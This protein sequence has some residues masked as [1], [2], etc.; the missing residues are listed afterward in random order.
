MKK[1]I[2]LVLSA[3]FL[4]AGCSSGENNNV[5]F[6]YCRDTAAYQYFEEDGVIQ[7]ETRDLP[8]H[9]NDL[10]YMIGLYLAGPIKEGLESPFPTSTQILSLHLEEDILSIELSDLTNTLTDSEYTLACACLT[11]TCLN[12]AQ[13]SAVQISSGNRSIRMSNETMILFDSLPQQ[14]TTGG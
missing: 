5:P 13:C 4:L 7:K 12:I 8:G 1:Y 2:C 14:E 9:R 11:L 6:F 3:L 10:H